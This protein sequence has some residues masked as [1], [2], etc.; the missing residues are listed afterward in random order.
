MVTTVIKDGNH[1]PEN[2]D[3]II[4]FE[5]STDSREVQESWEKSRKCSSV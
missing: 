2:S 4:G 3:N 1:K 5:N